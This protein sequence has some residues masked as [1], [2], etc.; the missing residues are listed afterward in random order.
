MLL[1]Q[2]VRYIYCCE[3]QQRGTECVS[4]LLLE[5]RYAN[6]RFPPAAPSLLHWLSVF[7]AAGTAQRAGWASPEYASS[8]TLGSQLTAWAPAHRLALTGCDQHS[9]AGAPAVHLS[10]AL[11]PV[12]MLYRLPVA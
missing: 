9:W 8:V 12:S 10:A 4:D 2:A 7:R 11:S 3:H 1:A 6:L 5:S